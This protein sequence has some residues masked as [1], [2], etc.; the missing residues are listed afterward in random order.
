MVSP[1]LVSNSIEYNLI[2]K[3]HRNGE[4][5]AIRKEGEG[6]VGRGPSP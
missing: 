2:I 1:L 6:K 5:I 3:D 4:L